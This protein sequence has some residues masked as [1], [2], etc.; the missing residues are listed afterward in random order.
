MFERNFEKAGAY[1]VNWNAA[2]ENG[3][4]LPSGVYLVSL[5]NGNQAKHVKATLLR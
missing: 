4:P 2:S 1:E 3:D 5:K